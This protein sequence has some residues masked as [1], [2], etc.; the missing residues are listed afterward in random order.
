M[1]LAILLLLVWLVLVVRFPRV[2]LPVSG[3]LIALS[4]LLAIGVGVR[5]WHIERQTSKVDISIRHAPDSCDFGKPLAVTIENRSKRTANRVS[6]H[7]KALQPGFNT[8]LV[9][10]GVS[11][12]IYQVSD[13]LPAGAQWQG[14]YSVPRL[15]SGY[16]AD[17]LEYH[18][19]QVRADFSD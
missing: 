15:R 18:A 4:V 7:L 12:N 19:A 1:P 2:M 17:D 5:Q 6:W 13:A 8:N 10:V 16:R 9:D 11:A 3:I 14:C